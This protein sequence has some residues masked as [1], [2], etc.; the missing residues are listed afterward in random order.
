MCRTR[1]IAQLTLCGVVA[2][3]LAA[4]GK[5]GAASLLVFGAGALPCE[6]WLQH[7]QIED[8]DHVVM[9]SW[10][11]GYLTAANEGR[12][13]DGIRASFGQNT[14]GAAR[15]AWVTQYC[16]SHPND[17]LFRAAGALV[18]ILQQR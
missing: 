18:V 16:R 8:P 12:S 9:A 13:A 7:A 15:D 17:S 14:E 11:D 3:G 5:S 6:A 1:L 4:S 2:I 10:I